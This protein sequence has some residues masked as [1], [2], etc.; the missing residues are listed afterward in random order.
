ML[1]VLLL[2][3]LELLMALLLL[4]RCCQVFVAPVKAARTQ[5]H[6]WVLLLLLLQSWLHLPLLQL[7]LRLLMCQWQGLCCCLPILLLLLQPAAFCLLFCALLHSC[8]P[9][10]SASLALK[11]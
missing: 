4:L 3:L 2:L 6:C 10:A 1:Q 5:D 7:L 11:T 8:A 9:A